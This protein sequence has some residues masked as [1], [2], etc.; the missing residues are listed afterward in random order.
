MVLNSLV[1]RKPGCFCFY[2]YQVKNLTVKKLCDIV[3]SVLLYLKC[4][5]LLSQ[6]VF[7]VENLV[8]GSYGSADAGDCR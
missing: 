7:Y 3:Y 8:V 5:H 2:Y 6:G 1:S 4:S